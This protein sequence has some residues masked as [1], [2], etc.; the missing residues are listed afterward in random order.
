M[1]RG[2]KGDKGLLTVVPHLPGERA[3]PPEGMSEEA[4][5]RW[6]EIVRGMRSEWFS[7]GM[8]P[9]LEAYCVEAT[10]AK[11][12]ELELDKAEFG[13]PA[14]R[15]V[16]SMHRATCNTLAQL[17]VRLRMTP[18]A[19]RRVGG[20]REVTTSSFRPWEA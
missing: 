12:L 7:P 6:T 1:Q 14:Y 16:A 18:S 13:T 9:L 19:Q 20:P 17:A 3:P 4:Q 8:S 11:Q 10:I 2:R 5:S 15:R